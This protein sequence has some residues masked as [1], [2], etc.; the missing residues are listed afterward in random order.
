MVRVTI[1]RQHGRRPRARA[2]NR[3]GS[4][5]HRSASSSAPQDQSSSDGRSCCCSKSAI[6]VLITAVC[7]RRSSLHLLRPV[8]VRNIPVLRTRGI[9]ETFLPPESSLYGPND[10]RRARPYKSPPSGP[11]GQ[12]CKS[13]CR[14][15]K[16]CARFSCRGNVEV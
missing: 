9:A 15:R 7:R 12:V 16:P 11:L 4:R 10:V 1:Q 2:L 8:P 14:N 6:E 3:A 13:F 5:E